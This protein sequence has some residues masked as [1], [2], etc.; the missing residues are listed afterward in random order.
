MPDNL[1]SQFEQ[2]RPLLQHVADSLLA[3]LREAIKDDGPC[4]DVVFDVATADKFV[5][6]ARQL[7]GEN[8]TPLV[9]VVA[10]IVGRIRVETLEDANAIEA[11]VDEFLSTVDRSWLSREDGSPYLQL[12]CS[13]PPQAK[14]AGWE[15]RVDVPSLFRLIIEC[16]PFPS[17]S[18]TNEIERLDLEVVE[19]EL[20]F[21]L[22]MKGG[23]IKGLAYAGA[24]EVLW[25]RYRFNWFVGTS[26][27]AVAAVLL[28]AGYTPREVEGILRDKDFTDFFDSPW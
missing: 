12:D 9:E 11:L 26:A 4:A 13:I 23:G 20:P 21:A 27:G 3:E 17:P 18:R 5:A 10:Q 15:R 22:I 24:L 28:G 16:R 14:P 19:E 6:L 7:E 2:R 25:E 1:A 8:R